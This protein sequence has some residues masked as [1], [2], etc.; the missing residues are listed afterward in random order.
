MP[1]EHFPARCKP[2]AYRVRSWLL[3]DAPLFLACAVIAG[4]YAAVYSPLIPSI[5]PR[6]HP[7]ESWVNLPT[8]GVIWGVLAAGLL[9][10]AVHERYRLAMHTLSAW[11]GVMALWGMKYIS[12]WALGEWER[13]VGV[14]VVHVTVPVIVAWAVWRGSRA[15]YI[16]KAEREVSTDAS[17][18]ELL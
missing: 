18:N 17:S 9:I 3:G 12:T 5:M 10:T 2:V 13:G 16:V 4:A 14:G 8:W 11:S 15:E 1:I 7:L 6:I